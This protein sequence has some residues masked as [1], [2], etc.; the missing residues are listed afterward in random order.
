VIRRI[1]ALFAL[2]GLAATGHAQNVDP[3]RI[4]TLAESRNFSGIILVSRGD[5]IVYARAFGEIEPGSGETHRLDQRW[6]WASITK[7]L[8]ATIAMQQVAAGRMELDAPVSRYWPDFPN[9]A[10]ETITI[11]HLLQH[12]SGLP[13]P[14]D[15]PRMPSGLPAFYSDGWAD[16]ASARGYCAGPSRREAG[17]EYQYTNC[18]YIV[19]GALLERV[20]G[21]EMDALLAALL[22]GTQALF[23]DG[24]PTVPGFHHGAAEPPIRF[25][26]YGTAGGFNGTI[27]D[28]WRFDR[29]LMRGDLLDPAWREEMWTGDPSIGYAALG[30]W[31]FPAPL[32]GCETSVRLVERPGAIGGV[33]GRNYILPELDMAVIAFTNRT[34]AEFPL[35]NIADDRHFAFDLLSTAVCPEQA[36]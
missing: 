14:D 8:V 17:L 30:Q 25:T 13:D 29:A 12:L 23:P 4:G 26:A 33:Q 7:Q 9:P 28:L 34:E 21:Q 1:A 3:V 20:T 35:G 22:P 15:T 31:V 18:D 24:G 10:R 6:R 32:S 5:T 27:F 36:P 16:N 11:R 19:L 2:C